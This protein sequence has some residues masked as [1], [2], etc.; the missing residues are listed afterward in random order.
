MPEFFLYPVIVVFVG[1]VDFSVENTPAT[2]FTLPLYHHMPS[3]NDWN[4]GESL[5]FVVIATL[6]FLDTTIFTDWILIKLLPRHGFLEVVAAAVYKKIFA[7][8]ITLEVK[9]VA[10]NFKILSVK[11]P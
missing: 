4:Q 11:F 8:S 9:M 2:P 7:A 5:V 6:N 3:F 1:I 10:L